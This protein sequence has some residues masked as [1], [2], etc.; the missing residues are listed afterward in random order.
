MLLFVRATPSGSPQQCRGAL[1]VRSSG[2]GPA[3]VTTPRTGRSL[4]RAIRPDLWSRAKSK[5]TPFDFCVLHAC[6]AH[7]PLRAEEWWGS[8]GAIVCKVF[9]PTR[10]RIVMIDANGRLAE[11]P[12]SLLVNSCR[13]DL[14]SN[15]MHYWD[16][17]APASFEPLPSSTWTS[18][19]GKEH[20]IDFGLDPVGV[21][22]PCRVERSHSAGH[23]RTSGPGGSWAC[24]H[25][26]F[27]SAQAY[28]PCPHFLRATPSGILKQSKRYSSSTTVC[29]PSLQS[30]MP[31][32]LAGRV[33][34]GSLSRHGQFYSG[35]LR[36][37]RFA[38]IRRCRRS[39]LFLAF[40]AW[41]R[42]KQHH[43]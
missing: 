37:T 26:S 16:M 38:T 19:A 2:S 9:R 21:A 23:T 4:L 41:H 29:R 20:E 13:P 25:S 24:S 31:P 3:S 17:E 12:A 6:S 34:P 33:D 22:R 15:H 28:R 10:N 42:H 1:A 11:A 14:D 40:S 35:F 32:L 36:R 5:V 30:A 39:L 18:R 8:T 43:R 7:T 27:F